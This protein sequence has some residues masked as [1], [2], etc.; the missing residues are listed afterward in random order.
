[1]SFLTKGTQPRYWMIAFFSI[2]VP[3]VYTSCKSNQGLFSSDKTQHEKYG[4]NI[5]KAGLSNTSLGNAWFKAA[6]Q[7]LNQPADIALPYRESGFFS[8]DQPK[9][10]GLRFNVRHGEKINIS[11]ITVP[12]SAILFTELWS[13]A[14]GSPV[15]LISAADSAGK[16]L[17][18]E[19]D[20]DESL[21]LRIQSELLQSV[22]Y[23][24]SVVTSPSL[25]FPVPLNNQPRVSSFWGADRDGG[26]RKHEGVDIFAKKRTPL[27]AAADGK[28]TRVNEN[29]LGGK[30]V[31]MRPHDK[32]YTLYYAHLDSQLV[33]PGQ[34]VKTGDVIGLM[35]NS[36]NARTTPAHL[37]FGI[38]ARGG[39]VDPFPF[40]NQERPALPEVVADK[41]IL[42][43][44]A[45]LEKGATI[46]S[47]PDAKSS[48]IRK[49][50]EREVMK[51]NGATS[52]WYRVEWA[53]SLFGFIQ[54]KK[55][56]ASPIKNQSMQKTAKL[57]TQPNAAAPA[58]KAI[59]KGEQIALIGKTN[60]Y[61]FVQYG[62]EKGWINIAA[63]D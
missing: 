21:I 57:L 13:A 4:E 44:Y 12:D 62:D 1:M 10:T 36:G 41:K 33:A 59:E 20:K 8:D 26:I 22:E 5:R 28:V 63:L 56:I 45:R 55:L 15:K 19:A 11:I 54:E 25:A 58:R 29:N 9:S 3:F 50:N 40:I 17:H 52:D 39:A 47:L 14:E 48:V 27:I 2:V 38:Y 30:V 51:I 31:F 43:Q 23:T 60:E 34:D 37:H 61:Y 32:N 7:G 16:H 49:S 53:D 18:L 35:G 6:S 42:N 46:F 24:V